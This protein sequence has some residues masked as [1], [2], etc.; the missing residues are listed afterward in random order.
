MES[1]TINSKIPSKTA[2]I[3][4]ANI[5][6]AVSTPETGNSS[7][8]TT[9]VPS[10]SI[11]NSPTALSNEEVSLQ[12]KKQPQGLTLHKLIY[13]DFIQEII[14]LLTCEM[15]SAEE[16]NLKQLELALQKRKNALVA[17]KKTVDQYEQ[18]LRSMLTTVDVEIDPQLLFGLLQLLKKK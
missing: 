7:S 14:N 2:I 4:A 15:I 13:I 16:K 8:V 17:K 1:V 3:T 5:Q 10:T 11:F 12:Y 18:L 9:T 6:P